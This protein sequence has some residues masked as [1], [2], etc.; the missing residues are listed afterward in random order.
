MNNVP[1]AQH[2]LLS[3]CGAAPL[4]T[5]AGS[6]HWLCLPHFDSP[7]LLVRLLDDAAGHFRIAPVG[8]DASTVALSDPVN[9]SP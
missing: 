3:D 5:A 4:V 1:V 6:V 8:A 7:P 2:A 9:V